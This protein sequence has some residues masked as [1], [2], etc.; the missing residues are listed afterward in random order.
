MNS[1]YPLCVLC[2]KTVEI[3][4]CK[5]RC[6]DGQLLFSKNILR[7]HNLYFP[8]DPADWRHG[9][10]VHER[11][12]GQQ[13]SMQSILPPSLKTGGNRCSSLLLSIHL[14]IRNHH[15]HFPYITAVSSNEAEKDGVEKGEEF[16]GT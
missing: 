3:I 4:L 7:V 13:D 10:L 1:H 5:L 9:D 12:N 8:L 2:F 11:G 15:A 16:R 14:F 6:I